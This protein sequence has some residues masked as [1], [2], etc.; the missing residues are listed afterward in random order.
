MNTGLP[1]LELSAGPPTPL[2]TWSIVPAPRLTVMMWFSRTPGVTGTS[3]P[4]S[5]WIDGSFRLNT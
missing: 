4:F 3:K 2:T 1:V 5:V